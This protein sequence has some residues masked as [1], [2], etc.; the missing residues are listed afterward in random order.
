MIAAGRRWLPAE[1]SRNQRSGDEVLSHQP[2]ELNR[3][4]AVGPDGRAGI[5]PQG[6]F[7]AVVADGHRLDL[8]HL[9]AG[10][11]DRV[12]DEVLTVLNWA[13]NSCPRWKEPPPSSSKM[14][15]AA[16]TTRAK[17]RPS[18]VSSELFMDGT[19]GGCR[20]GKVHLNSAARNCCNSG[21]GLARARRGPE[22]EDFPSPE[23][24][25]GRQCRR[26]GRGRGSRSRV[27]PVRRFRFTIPA[28]WSARRADPSSLVGSSNSTS[29]G[30]TTRARAIAARLRMPPESSSDTSGPHPGVRA[31]RGPAF[32]KRSPRFPRG[33]ESVF[34]EIESDVFLDGQGIQQ[35]AALKHHGEAVP[36]IRGVGTNFPR[37]PG[38]PPRRVPR[39]PIRCRRKTDFPEPLGPMITKISPAWMSRSRLEHHPSVKAACAGRERDRGGRGWRKGRSCV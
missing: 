16:M 39:S 9:D 28:R 32:S 15:K 8:A 38:S 3:G 27:A 35:S 5:D 34:G 11:F 18:R 7:H 31:A 30:S 4:H 29:S 12:A 22:R 37:P 25:A 1:P 23:T 19:A 13:R 26:Q 36:R 20:T 2:G 21:T 6:H 33:L 10:Q 14:M 17:N 24:P